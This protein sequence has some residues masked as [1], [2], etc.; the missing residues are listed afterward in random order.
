MCQSKAQATLTVILFVALAFI[1]L[2]VVS[3]VIVDVRQVQVKN[4]LE[5]QIEISDK[6]GQLACLLSSGSPQLTRMEMIGNLF[7]SDTA[8]SLLTG[9][10]DSRL[11]LVNI[12]KGDVIKT[13]GKDVPNVKKKFDA[14]VPLPGAGLGGEIKG[15]VRM[16]E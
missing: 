1:V 5:L 2:M 9:L 15:A 8:Y 16:E 11:S 13:F 14:E 10:P 3:K 12:A 6:G 4:V 7:F